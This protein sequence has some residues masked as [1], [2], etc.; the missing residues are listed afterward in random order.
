MSRVN[1]CLIGVGRM[2]RD[3][4]RFIQRS[5][6][7]QVYCVVDSSQ[8]LAQSVAKELGCKAYTSVEEALADPQ[9]EAV[10][11]ASSTD[12]HAALIM[13]A[14]RAGKPIFCEKPIDLDIQRVDECLAVVR[15]SNV[16]LLI[17]FNRRFDPSFQA[18]ARRLHAGEIGHLESV[19]IYSRDWRLPSH[20]YLKSSGGMFRDMTV[21]DF[22]IARWLL[23][24][25]PLEV[26][27]TGSCL[28]D[29][30]IA[31]FGD[32]DSALV[33]LK[34]E[35]GKLCQISNSRRSVF[36]YDQ[37]LE[38]FGS[39]GML[40]ADNPPQTFV[41]YSG[42]TGTVTDQMY[43]SFPQRYAQAYQ[44]EIDHFFTDVVQGAKPPYI[45][46]RDGRQAI[47]IADAAQE[48]YETG[49][50]V[51]IAELVEA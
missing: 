15:E 8:E 48:S 22:D 6:H 44:N 25:E 14:A 43:P 29:P 42:E 19:S 30:S 12:T 32:L 18:F 23:Q 21:H 2:G 20:D 28:I 41:R 36:G 31:E 24:E 26:Y 9:V 45:S 13:Q 51:R 16:P 37:R 50:P 47:V 39:E 1:C 35:S 27:A 38:A 11:I 40:Q 3:H 4:A 10:A 46:G 5:E 7:G 49:K 17:G 33:V 34:T